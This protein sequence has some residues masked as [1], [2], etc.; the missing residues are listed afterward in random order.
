[1]SKSNIIGSAN[2]MENLALRCMT[3]L[4]TIFM[5][6]LTVLLVCVIMSSINSSNYSNIIR[7]NCIG[8]KCYCKGREYFNN[9]FSI[10]QK[11]SYQS[12]P[13]LDPTNKSLLFG[14]AN[15]YIYVD[16]SENFNY[17]LDIFCNL[18]VLDGN[19][20]ATPPNVSHTYYATLKN[21][22][23]QETIKLGALI[24]DGDG[25]Y[26]LKYTT[27]DKKLLGFDELNITYMLNGNE[28]IMLRGKF[29]DGVL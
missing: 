20:Y 5:C 12:I 8:E 26:K 11:S 13:L 25:I 21:N 29:K 2:E 23:T 18:F 9:T 6:S 24:K 17:R 3:S 4:E 28:E 14:Q 7:C 10:E 1:M 15:R 19:I 22:K 16:Q 27:L